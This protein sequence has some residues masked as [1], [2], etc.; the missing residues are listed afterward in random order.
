MNQ[1]SNDERLVVSADNVNKAYKHLLLNPD[2]QRDLTQMINLPL[3]NCENGVY[4]LKRVS[5]K[6]TLRSLD[7]HHTFKQNM[8]KT[9]KAKYSSDF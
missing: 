2:I 5:L 4:N 1:F 8:I 7:L 6:N 3:I 9:L